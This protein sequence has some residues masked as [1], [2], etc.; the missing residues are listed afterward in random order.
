MENFEL[1]PLFNIE[2]ISAASGL[3]YKDNKL[4][5]LGEINLK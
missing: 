4:Y 3:V 1:S 5:P 2:G